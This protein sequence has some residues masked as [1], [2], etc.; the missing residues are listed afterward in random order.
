MALQRIVRLTSQDA[1]A[2]GHD[3][4]EPVVFF[5]DRLSAR[6]RALL[7]PHL[8]TAVSRPSPSGDPRAVV[9]SIPAHCAAAMAQT[10][11]YACEHLTP[12]LA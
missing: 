6:V 12:V 1:V 9:V 3:D 8:I 4:D 2:I 10:R 7:F 11:C 5:S